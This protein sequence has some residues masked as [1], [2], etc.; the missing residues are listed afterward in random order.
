M[1]VQPIVKHPSK[2]TIIKL[3]RKKSIHNQALSSVFIYCATL[4]SAFNFAPAF[5][6]I[7]PI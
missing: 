4:V 3:C 5:L 7:F 6:H 2:G 1:T